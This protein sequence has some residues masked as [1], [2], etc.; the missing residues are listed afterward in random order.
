VTPY[1][2]GCELLDKGT[3]ERLG[4]EV[5]LMVA[6]HTHLVYAARMSRSV[7]LLSL[8]RFKVI[9]YSVY[10]YR[11]TSAAIPF[12]QITRQNPTSARANRTTTTMET[13]DHYCPPP[14]STMRPALAPRC[15]VVPLSRNR[16]PHS[17]SDGPSAQGEVRE[18]R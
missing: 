4:M 15:R 13:L 16:L 10:R 17:A 14:S 6:T 3:G 11:L 18:R 12:L 5:Y 8:S 1:L 2:L 9:W 7:N